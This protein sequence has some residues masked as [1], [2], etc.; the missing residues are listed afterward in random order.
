MT[1]DNRANEPSHNRITIRAFRD[2][3]VSIIHEDQVLGL[4]CTLDELKRAVAT[5]EAR[6]ALVAV[7]VAPQPACLN[8]DEIDKLIDDS[9]AGLLS[10]GAPS[11]A[12]VEAAAKVLAPD[13]VFAEDFGEY[14]RKR[15]NCRR[16]DQAEEQR[17]YMRKA[18]AALVAAAGAAPQAESVWVP[19]YGGTGV[20]KAA[21]PVNSFDTTA[22]HAK[23]GADSLHVAPQE[24]SQTETKSGNNFVSLDPEKVAELIEQLRDRS[25]KERDVAKE[26]LG[27]FIA[28]ALCEAYTEG[29]L[30]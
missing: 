18:R 27:Q 20:N 14:S 6:A 8:C 7:G 16:E 23:N 12:Q 10:E 2:G 25:R 4:A 1:I 19:G 21:R 17:Y 26:S 30:T 29:K 13:G 11:E 3:E 15:D 22:E 5:Y 28:R 24:P 9:E